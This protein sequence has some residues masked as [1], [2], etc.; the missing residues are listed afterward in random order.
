MKKSMIYKLKPETIR[1][2]EERGSLFGGLVQAD[3][4]RT[5][6]RAEHARGGQRTCTWRHARRHKK[7]QE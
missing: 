4:R 1:S 7:R 6:P 5:K 2:H 3:W